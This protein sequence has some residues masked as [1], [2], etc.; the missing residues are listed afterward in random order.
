MKIDDLPWIKSKRISDI[1]QIRAIV[2]DRHFDH[3]PI[4]IKFFESGTG[5]REAGDRNFQSRME[6]GPLIMRK[7]TVRN[8]GD[9]PVGRN[10]L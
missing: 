9:T 8:Q 6:F 4:V 7:F 5:I 2:N 10:D 3:R 1:R